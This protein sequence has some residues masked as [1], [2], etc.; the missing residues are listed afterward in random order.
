LR[1]DGD[2]IPAVIQKIVRRKRHAVSG[3][4]F[5][6]PAALRIIH[7][8]QTI[9]RSHP[10]VV[11]HAN[12]PVFPIPCVG[13]A[14]VVGQVA[15]GI[16]GELF[17]FLGH[18]EAAAG[19]GGGAGDG[20]GEPGRSGGVVGADGAV[21]KFRLAVHHGHAVDGHVC[22]HPRR[23]DD[24]VGSGHV[25]L[26]DLVEVA[27][28]VIGHAKVQAVGVA[29]GL[30]LH[31]V[32]DGVE[33]VAKLLAGHGGAV[34][35]IAFAGGHLAE[36]VVLINPVGAVREGVL[37]ALVGGVVV[38]GI[39]RS[40][41]PIAGGQRRNLRQPVQIII[42]LRG[43]H[44]RS[45][46]GGEDNLAHQGRIGKIR[47]R[48]GVAMAVV[49]G[50]EAGGG[51][52]AVGGAAEGAGAKGGQIRAA[53]ELVVGVGDGQAVQRAAGEGFT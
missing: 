15:V 21:E 39:S 14:A 37:G 11:G 35:P 29:A 13:P 19:A 32:A 47:I 12:Q 10:G 3:H 16:V 1:K 9:E 24:V 26:E 5:L 2:Q 17:G 53:H 36:G 28:L 23:A 8:T 33:G 4:D 40:Q 18:V 38:V 43:G 46:I 6:Y 44:P 27:D 7:E 20:D 42:L 31:P 49:D 41:Q 50:G 51:V 34:G 22:A 30:G 25:A 52:V 48:G 45:A